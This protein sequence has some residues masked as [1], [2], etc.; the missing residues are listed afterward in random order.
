VTARAGLVVVVPRNWPGD[1]AAVVAEK[2]TWAERALASVAERRALHVA[3]PEAMLPSAI[4]LRAAGCVLPVEYTQT[5]S[6]GTRARWEGD[7]VV[8][9]G[10]IADAE[11]CML[12]LRRWLMRTARQHLFELCAEL[13]AAHGM[14]LSKVRVTSARSRWGSCSSRGTISLNRNLLFL[15][16]ELADA[17]VLH[18]LAHLRVLDHSPRFWS[19]LVTMDPRAHEHRAQLKQACRFVPPWADA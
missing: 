2:R 9:S 7:N 18:E 10:N 11:E 15:P 17:L 1:V 16:P 14:A 13:S 5:R 8:V 12:A 4:S 19:L 6:A 3:G